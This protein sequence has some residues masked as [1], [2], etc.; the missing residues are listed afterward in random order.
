MWLRLLMDNISFGKQTSRNDS[1]HW[2]IKLNLIC[3]H[4]YNFAGPSFFL[5]PVLTLT[6][7]NGVIFSVQENKQRFNI[8]YYATLLSTEGVNLIILTSCMK[9][10][11]LMYCAN[12]KDWKISEIVGKQT[13]RNDSTH[14]SIKINLICQ[15]KYNFAGPMFFIS[16]KATIGRCYPWRHVLRSAKNKNTKS[17]L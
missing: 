11:K 2:S 6:C 16:L 17:V 1:S 7:L 4:K 15:Y 10:S 12:A 14:W 8:N 13:S 9:I 3:Q 5:R